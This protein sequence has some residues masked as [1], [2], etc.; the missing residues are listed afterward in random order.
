[1]EII[2]IVGHDVFELESENEQ[3]LEP[4]HMNKNRKQKTHKKPRKKGQKT[5]KNKK[6]NTANT[7]KDN[8]VK[9]KLFRDNVMLF[10]SITQCIPMIQSPH[11]VPKN[12]YKYSPKHWSN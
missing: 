5:R 8:T 7:N 6:K 1:M 12:I 9:L 3:Q 10:E 4:N 11:H 2:D